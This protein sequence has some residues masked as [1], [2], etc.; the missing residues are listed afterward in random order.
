M[1]RTVLVLILMSLPT[2]V[3]AHFGMLIPSTN[4]VTADGRQVQLTLSFSHPAEVTGMTL[5]KPK[6]FFSVTEGKKTDLLSTLSS[7]QVMGHQGWQADIAVKRP[8]VISYVM[9]PTPY[10]E[11]AEDVHIIHIT[12]TIVSAFGADVGWDEPLGLDTEIVPLLRPFGNYAGNAFVGQVLMNGKP[13]PGAEVEVERYNQ[14]GKMK[15]ASDLHI[16]QVIKADANGVFTFTCPKEGWWGFAALNEADYTLKDP[17][18]KDKGVELGA[19][20]WIYLDPVSP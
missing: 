7:V 8:G 3:W 10:W 2:V 19:V 11:P 15:P 13:V 9:E 1:V 17:S 20:L 6:A 14:D 12:K 18:G 4:Q 5:K 16:T